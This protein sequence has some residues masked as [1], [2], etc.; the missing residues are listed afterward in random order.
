MI[1]IRS[2]LRVRVVTLAALSLLPGCIY[3]PQVDTARDAMRAIVSPASSLRTPAEVRAYPYAQLRMQLQ[4]FLPAIAVLSEYVDGDYLWLAGGGFRLLQ[5]PDGRIKQM[6]IGSKHVRL[7]WRSVTLHPVP[8]EEYVLT[9]VLEMQSEH[10]PGEDRTLSARCELVASEATAIVVNEQ[11]IDTLR[12]SYEC[13][14]ADSTKSF[15]MTYWHD[16]QGR[17]RR[18]LGRLWHGGEEYRFETLKVPA[19]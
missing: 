12:I 10:P 13:A 17:M 1:S 2:V 7:D 9:T 19:A 6:A 3:N 11:A 5:A 8:P 16:D 14:S 4:G 18:S 15:A